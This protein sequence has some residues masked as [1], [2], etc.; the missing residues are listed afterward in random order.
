MKRFP[1]LAAA[2]LA[3][4]VA[5]PLRAELFRP[6]TVHGA[7]IGGLAGAVIGHNDGRH[8]WEGAAYGAA[9]GALIGTAVG[10]ANDRA[11]YR[12]TQ[13]HVRPSYPYRGYGYYG[14]RHGRAGHRW[15]HSHYDRGWHVYY[16]HRGWRGPHWGSSDRWYSQPRYRT[17]YPV[18]PRRWDRPSYAA[19]GALLGGIAGAIIGHN[20]GRHGWEGAAYGLGAGYLLGSWADASAR[21]REAEAVPLYVAPRAVAPAVEATAPSQVT[22]I[23]NYYASPNA[24]ALASAN[25]MFGR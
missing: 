22:I 17:V 1:L 24:S 7:V 16:G 18:Y 14:S 5:A 9:A 11:D 3:A 21:R 8:G 20:D 2:A 19:R 25:G 15:G 12:R 10:H 23:N 6:E 13:P 4:S